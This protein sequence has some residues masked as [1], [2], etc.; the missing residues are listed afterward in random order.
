MG[1]NSL[2][3]LF[4]LI[5]KLYQIWPVR[6][7]SVWFLCPFGMSSSFFKH[8]LTS[9][10]KKKLQ[11]H[12]VLSLYQPWN[13]PFLQGTLV[14]FNK[15]WYLKTNIWMLDVLSTIEMSL[16]PGPFWWTE[17]GNIYTSTYCIFLYLSRC[18]ENH[19]SYQHVKTFSSL[20]FHNCN[21][22]LRQ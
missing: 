3:K 2:L 6:A 18:I 15:E 21:S 19:G 14:S 16:F 22:L 11:A 4:S 1:Y 9:G 7:P 8:F 17:V 12:F 5:L 20:L 13:Q 10:H